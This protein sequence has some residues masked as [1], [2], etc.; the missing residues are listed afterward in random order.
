[1]NLFVEFILTSRGRVS[2]LETLGR[3]GVLSCESSREVG[4]IFP[5]N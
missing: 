5:E 1:M 3:G 2:F 4:V